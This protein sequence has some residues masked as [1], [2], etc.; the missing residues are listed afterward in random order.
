[1]GSSAR[2]A[3]RAT[4]TAWQESG[5]RRPMYG[6]A[7]LA[8]KALHAPSDVSNDTAGTRRPEYETAELFFGKLPQNVE[9]RCRA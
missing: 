6:N 8:S 4:G 9:G 7:N 5:R 2:Q 1:M 3:V